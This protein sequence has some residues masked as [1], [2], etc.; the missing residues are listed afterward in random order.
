[1]DVDFAACLDVGIYRRNGGLPPGYPPVEVATFW[2]NICAPGPIETGT[3]D[4][5]V[6]GPFPGCQPG[7]E[8]QYY[9]VL[10]PNENLV[11][12]DKTNNVS[13]AAHLD[14]RPIE[15]ASAG[16]N[17]LDNADND[18]DGFIDCEDMDD[19]V[20]GDPCRQDA[21]NICDNDAS[22]RIRGFMQDHYGHPDYSR[23]TCNGVDD[24]SWGLPVDDFACSCVSDQGCDDI[25][26]MFRCYTEL[27]GA[28]FAPVCGRSCDMMPD[29]NRF[30]D[31][32]TWGN[33]PICQDGR[34]VAPA[35]EQP[36]L[37]A[38]IADV[39]IH[40][41][42]ER[43]FDVEYKVG[44][45]GP[46]DV[47]GCF[48]VGLIFFNEDTAVWAAWDEVLHA[49]DEPAG[50]N[51]MDMWRMYYS[52]DLIGSHSVFVYIDTYDDIVE[53]DENDNLRF[54]QPPYDLP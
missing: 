19:L 28:D 33:L 4:W 3:C 38:Y 32:L 30:C 54:A 6:L 14:L 29:P 18:G 24:L 39:L 51:H 25:N 5:V 21:M 9:A 15:S 48:T 41:P 7:E 45:E 46:G 20:L 44:N 47:S 27:E 42:E 26:P 35:A 2:T 50:W 17:C 1:M 8:L 37:V 52:A 34:C 13:P 23:E 49:C 11:E 16:M 10:D 43:C 22:R 40:N 53:I 31:E 12:S 36:N